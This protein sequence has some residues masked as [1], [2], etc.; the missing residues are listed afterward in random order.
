MLLSFATDWKKYKGVSGAGPINLKAAARFAETLS[1]AP[2]APPGPGRRL[3]EEGAARP[4]IAA[5]MAINQAL[6]QSS[7]NQTISQL[8]SVGVVSKASNVLPA[9]YGN[10]TS[11]PMSFRTG[12]YLP[13]TGRWD[14][15]AKPLLLPP[16]RC[17]RSGP[18]LL[19]ARWAVRAHAMREYARASGLAH[20]ECPGMCFPVTSHPICP[21]STLVLESSSVVSRSASRQC[22]Q[23]LSVM[24]SS[25]AQA[26]PLCCPLP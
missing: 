15:Q 21:A 5:M 13:V 4:T 11:P 25:F 24:G 26:C 6:Q 23:H 7:W 3:F 16:S 10:V 18:S 9:W 1:S 17:H 19:A 22:F 8:Q 12:S 14:G 2:A 20:L